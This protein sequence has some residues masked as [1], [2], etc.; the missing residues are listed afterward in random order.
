MDLRVVAPPSFD[1]G[2]SY[3]ATWPDEEQREKFDRLAAEAGGGPALLH[4]RFYR[5]VPGV[6]FVDEVS[7][8]PPSIRLRTQRSLT[9]MLK[10]EVTDRLEGLP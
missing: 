9:W 5:M 8:D 7:G 4:G 1:V 10:E 6:R 3:G 2:G